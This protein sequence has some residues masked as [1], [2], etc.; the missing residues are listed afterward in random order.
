MHSMRRLA[1]SAVLLCVVVQCSVSATESVAER[2]P[3]FAVS[4]LDGRAVK[5]SEIPVQQRSVLI[6]VVPNCRPCETL[7]NLIKKKEYPDL[8]SKAVVIVGRANTAKAVRIAGKFPDLHE[9]SWYADPSRDAFS[10]LKLRG[11]PVILGLRQN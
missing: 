1:I 5:S 11:V 9:A 4:A 10:K 2:V 7:L 6:Y 3:E 8:P